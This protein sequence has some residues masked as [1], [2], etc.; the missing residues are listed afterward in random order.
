MPKKTALSTQLEPNGFS[1]IESLICLS[2]FLIIILGVFQVFLISQEQF[3]SLKRSQLMDSLARAALDKI[4]A[5]LQSSGQMLKIPASLGLLDPISEADGILCSWS[6]KKRFSLDNSLIP[7]EISVPLNGTGEIKEGNEICIF[8]GEK[9][10]VKT[11]TSIE[12]NS[13]LLSSPLTNSYFSS[14]TSIF[15]LK[16]VSFYLEKNQEVLR[17]K[18]NS[19]P[20]QP[21]CEDIQTFECSYDPSSNLVTVRIKLKPEKEKNHEIFIFPKNAAL[22][23]ER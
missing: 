16:K 9:G 3:S 21:L 10:E 12:E 1:L 18:V 4:K 17:R 2:L 14:K 23:S 6:T 15:L 13:I 7:G 20:A 8:D 5:D 19:S 11:V 22:A